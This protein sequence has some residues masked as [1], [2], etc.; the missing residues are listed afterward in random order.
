MIRH[1]VPYRAT[2]RFPAIAMDHLEGAEGV[3]ELRTHA[4]DRS[5][6]AAAM[7][8]RTFDPGA[9]A[10][11]CA[12][13]NDQYAGTPV[14]PAVR[15]NL[16]ALRRDGTLT[17]TTGHQLC[18]FTGPLYVP[19]KILNAIRLARDLSTPERAVVP[20][21]WMATED[22]DRAEIDHAWINGT[23]VQ[24]P[25]SA[26]GAVGRLTLEGVQQTVDAATALLGPGAHTDE[27]VALLRKCYAEGATLAQATR[28]FVHALFG[29]F[30]LVIL[31]ADDVRLK[32][33]FVPAM[34]EELLNNVAQRSVAY[35]EERMNGHYALQAHAREINLF[36]LGAGTRSR[37]ERDGDRYHV[38]EGGPVFDLDG[39]LAELEAYPERFSPNVLLRP[40]YQETILPNVAYIGGGGELAYWLQLR[41]LFQALRVPMPVLMLR[42]S[43]VLV[44]PKDIA[45]WRSLGLDIADLFADVE[46]LHARV[47]SSRAAFATELNAE[48]DELNAFYD[49][50]ASRVGSVDSTLEAA[51]RSTGKHALTGLAHVEEKLMRA[52]KRQQATDLARLDG[53]LQRVF[54]D[55]TLHERRDNLLP[56]YAASGPA[57]LD[58][59]LEQLDP[60][61][62]VFSVLEG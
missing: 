58:E 51:A 15:A 57:F 9:R 35:A 6:L 49:R 22:H 47:A 7:A 17:V 20:V 24:W 14:E 53:V 10:I 50:L 26:S 60:L 18:L 29:R 30:G 45:L 34:Q 55:G 41:W 21:F 37:I 46:G 4:P 39:L 31:D 33:L 32:R 54:P 38:L 12:V 13:L 19:F 16:D 5:G 11:L 23:K 62:P 36:Y 52:A 43:A 44:R 2:G 42:T 48:R 8:A 28:A 1:V 40:I 59:L 27:V 56:W 3:R 61:D 25:G